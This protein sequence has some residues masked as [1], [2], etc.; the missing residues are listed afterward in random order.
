MIYLDK[1]YNTVLKHAVAELEEKKSRFIASVMPVSS[2]EEA[3]NFINEIKTKNWDATHNVYSY[4]IGGSS[5]IQRFSDDGEP[6]GTAGLPILEV[7]KRMEVR[8]LVVVV[9]RY[10]GGTLL[11]AAGLVRAYG[12]SASLAIEEAEIITKKLCTEVSIMVE[13]DLFGKVQNMLIS[14]DYI[15]KE[16]IYE[17][18]VEIIVFVDEG[19]M[20]DLTKLVNEV[21]N[22]RCIIEPGN[23]NYISLDAQGKL[24][25]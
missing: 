15:I 19:R 4:Y 2:E 16:I 7:I 3:L 1:Q 21:T 8:D 11:G 20:E 22:A 14:K 25:L 17:Q 10:F 12:K 5:I 24:I 9:T 18:D 6:S 23:K 13:Y